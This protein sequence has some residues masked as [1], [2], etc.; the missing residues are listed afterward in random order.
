MQNDKNRRR[1]IKNKNNK[2]VSGWE[3]CVWVWVYAWVVGRDSGESQKK[4]SLTPTFYLFIFSLYFLSSRSVQSTGRITSF[5]ACSMD[6]LTVI[7][8]HARTGI[9]R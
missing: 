5:D 1:H 6:F 8:L 4:V 9:L 7:A 2:K 3:V